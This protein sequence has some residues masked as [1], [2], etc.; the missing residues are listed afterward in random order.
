MNERNTVHF[1]AFL[2]ALEELAR[3]R[4][5]LNLHGPDSRHRLPI[6]SDIANQER[7]AFLAFGQAVREAELAAIN[8]DIE[9]AGEVE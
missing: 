3:F 7:L 5:L 9:E 8:R 2:K 1:D 6:Q 4:A